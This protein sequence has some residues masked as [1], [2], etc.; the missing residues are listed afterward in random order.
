MTSRVIILGA[1]FSIP[2]GIPQQNQILKSIFN[3]KLADLSHLDTAIPDDIELFKKFYQ[4]FVKKD[5]YFEIHL[6]DIYTSI[7]KAIVRQRNIGVFD[8][9]LLLY[10]RESL[11]RLIG[12]VINREIKSDDI[13]KYKEKL[14]FFFD[15]KK[16][17]KF[18]SLNWD[19][20]LEKVLLEMNFKI[21][22][23]IPLKFTEDIKGKG[24]AV[25]KPHGSLNWKLCPICEKIFAFFENEIWHCKNCHGIYS[26]EV[27]LMNELIKKR[28]IIKER[29]IPLLVTP[30]FLKSNFVPQL[31]LIMQFFYEYL[32]EAD[33]LHFIGYSLP[34]SD[35]DIRSVLLSAKSVNPHVNVSVILKS[36]NKTEI[37][38]LQN[39]YRSIYTENNIQFSFKGF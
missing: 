23:E 1:G 26:N 16:K 24:I 22:Y 27:S 32:I 35:H 34:L 2:A 10:I 13:E 21:D 4:Y 7:D 37:K 30:T 17:I 33:E 38:R 20:L 5:N 28:I 25:L 12:Y 19:F 6:E 36:K 8:A 15:K 31:N 9:S 39:N 3:I 14:S 18:I 11:D 29:L